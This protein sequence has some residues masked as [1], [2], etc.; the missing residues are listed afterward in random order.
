MDLY[1]KSS[2]FST[3]SNRFE[4]GFNIFTGIVI[5]STAGSYTV[6]V[7]REGFAGPTGDGGN[8]MQGIMLSSQLASFMG[9]KEVIV[10]QP[11]SRVLCAQVG[12]NSCYILG[13]IPQN[14]MTSENIPGRSMTG[15]G[16][17]HM[18]QANQKGHVD[19]NSILPIN[20]RP[21]DIVDGEYAIGDEFGTM[22][23]F[24]QQMITLKGSEL[25]QV[26]CFL[27]DDLV[28]II[29]HNFQHYTALGEYN[30]W[31]DGKS[32]MAEFGATHQ[33]GESYG[34][35][36]VESDSGAP[37][38]TKTGSNDVKD[39]SDF[40]K[41]AE[42]ERTR[43]IERFKVFIGRL[44]DFLH[45]YMVR[46][47][48]QETRGFD[49]TP[50]KPDTGLF[51]F[52]LGLD[53]GAHMRSVKEVF[54][55]KTNWIRVPHRCK[56]PADKQEG[57]VEYEK[58]YE[59][60]KKFEWKKE[61]KYLENP[62]FYFL[63]LRDYVAY[64]SEKKNYENFKK[65]EKDFY[66]NDSIGQ[67]NSLKQIDKVD[68]WTK[69]EQEE[70]ELRTAGIYLMPNGGVVIRD[71][72]N[73]AIVMEGG[74]I[75]LQ[76]AKDLHLQPLRNLVAKVGCFASIAAR[77]DV[78]ISSTEKGFRLKT[79]KAQYFYSDKSGIVF[80]ANPEKK[81]PYTPKPKDS[82]DA[83]E[84]VGGI[85]FKSTN[86]IY[87]YAEKEYKVQS[88]DRAIIMSKMIQVKAT[89]LL[90]LH[91][92]QAWIGTS[93]TS[94]ILHGETAALLLSLS[95][96]CIASGKTVS[97]YGMKDIYLGVM[98]DDKSPFIDPL[99][100]IVPLDEVEA[101]LRPG[102]NDLRK[103]EEA[104]LFDKIEKFTDLEF[105]FLK[106]HKYGS[107]QQQ[108]DAIP[109]TM[110]QQEEKSTGL[111]K[112]ETW[113]EKEIK[114][115]YPYPGKDKWEE[116]YLEGEKPKNLETNQLGKDSN[117]KAESEEKPAEITFKSLGQY[118]VQKKD[119]G[120]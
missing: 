8:M 66:V 52:H 72:W 67:E 35:P 34:R 1:T 100:G 68:K 119:G 49:K 106:S 4:K 104:F 44:G 30:I 58:N 113:K 88:T 10:P 80:E 74:Q 33:P 91:S 97:A 65:L 118:K 29:S 81:V 108:K 23:A 28:R 43:A 3:I 57:D 82:D 37:M 56:D 46:P 114:N 20:R 48:P 105:R 22:L 50:S 63:Q 89:Q 92:D 47:D 111:F 102:L 76:P 95:G 69:L 32:I 5:T 31:H 51:D 7:I 11:G 99:K 117:N 41:I 86:G 6:T 14:N 9:F 101:Q 55:E 45:A 12:A 107:L 116:F 24:F 60:K 39:D 78:D 38:F 64:V 120:N 87:N 54:I 19:K 2:D 96:A 18:E 73:S 115:S 70:Y 13:V 61:N 79:E 16:D 98:Y 26:Q 103:F 25:A 15:A 27:M 110:A 112:L 83:V 90:S 36:L 71:A 109:M 59:E 53:G 84:D 77:Y 42:D 40:Y 93:D 17:P 94:M 21:S 85:V 75:Y 62:H